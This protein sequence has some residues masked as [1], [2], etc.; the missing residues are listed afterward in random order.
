MKTLY[1]FHFDCGR[2][3]TLEGIFVAEDSEMEELVKSGRT[4][5]F[6]EALGKHSE[7]YGP[8]EDGDYTEIT[9]DQNFIQKMIDLDI[10]MGL[11]PVS[12]DKESRE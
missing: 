5:N 9:K 6:G 10:I 4:V 7:V 3:E 11:N 2:Y 8:I 1:K 12:I